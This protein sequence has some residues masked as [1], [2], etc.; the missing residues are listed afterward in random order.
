MHGVSLAPAAGSSARLRDR[1]LETV[2][3]EAQSGK[4]GTPVLTKQAVPWWMWCAVAAALL[5]AL[6]NSWDR[7]REQAIIEQTRREMAQLVAEQQKSETELAL[8]R[9]EALILTDP[10]SIKIPMPAVSKGLPALEATWHQ[11]LG[12]VITGRNIPAP[13][14]HRTF[15]LWLIPKAP[16]SKPVP[17]LTLRP[18][19]D[20][21]FD[22]LVVNP[23]ASAGATKA[24]AITEEP[25]AGSLEPTASPTWLGALGAT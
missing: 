12:I 9:H 25:E 15:E 22:L 17:S 6:Y 19:T 7:A 21:Q 8:A 1:L 4:T 2:R 3:G 5:F 24:L 14:T 23:P 11:G 18:A 16:G 20:G 10:A 13:A